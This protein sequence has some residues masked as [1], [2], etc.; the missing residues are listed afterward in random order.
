MCKDNRITEKIRKGI[1]IDAQFP[2]NMELAYEVLVKEAD[3]N[4]QRD[5]LHIV[6]QVDNQ[7]TVVKYNKTTPY[8]DANTKV[9][10]VSRHFTITVPDRYIPSKA[11]NPPE[12]IR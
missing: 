4:Q 5:F 2:R 8:I 3:F 12:E 9:K 10:C 1:L 11:E 6:E 7:Y